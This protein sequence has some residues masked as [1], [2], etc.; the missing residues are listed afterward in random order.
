LAYSSGDSGDISWILCTGNTKK[1]LPM[2]GA[3]F[4]CPLPND[5]LWLKREYVTVTESNVQIYGSSH[6]I[7]SWVHIHEA[8]SICGSGRLSHDVVLW[9]DLLVHTSSDIRDF[10]KFAAWIGVSSKTTFGIILVVVFSMS[11][12]GPGMSIVIPPCVESGIVTTPVIYNGKRVHIGRSVIVGDGP[13]RVPE[14]VSF[15]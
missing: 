10:L 5:N 4:L 11:I 3:R 14:K 9:S 2:Y 1:G 15:T 6:I 12:P 8:D 7:D 13:I